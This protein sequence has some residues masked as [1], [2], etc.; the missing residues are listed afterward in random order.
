MNEESQNIKDSSVQFVYDRN[1]DIKCDFWESNTRKLCC[2]VDTEPFDGPIFS[3]PVKRD[4]DTWIVKGVFCSL[5]CTK[6]YIIDTTFINTD[7]Y[8]LFTLMCMK[9]YNI[10]DSIIPAPKPY[11]LKKFNVFS[12]SSMNISEFRNQTL[13][14]VTEVIQPPVIPFHYQQYI[15]H[16]NRD[17]ICT[18]VKNKHIDSQVSKIIDNTICNNTSNDN[19]TQKT[20]NLSDYFETNVIDDI[21]IMTDEY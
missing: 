15:L 18:C 3:Y 19:I 5:Q 11:L 8:A 4:G 20:T 17:R 21:D 14:G 10:Y 6:R 7:M 13:R 12:N 9:V 1:N 2:W 16:S